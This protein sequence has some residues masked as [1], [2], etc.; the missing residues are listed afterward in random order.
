MSIFDPE[1]SLD[2]SIDAPL[3]K[4]PPIPVGDYTATIKELKARPWQGRKDPSR[5]GIAWDVKFDVTL[6]ND[7]A[8]LV[9]QPAIVLSDS[10]MLDLNDAGALDLSPGKN[11]GLRR[12]REALDMNKPGDAFS[13]RAMVGRMLK[14][15]VKHEI[16]EGEIQE[17]VG[18]VAR[19]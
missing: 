15:K 6:P 12:Y 10:I 13:A 16:Y 17:R 5:S 4:R 3:V 18:G 19:V 2:I 11:G 14:V 9:G 1:Q 7:V 8:S